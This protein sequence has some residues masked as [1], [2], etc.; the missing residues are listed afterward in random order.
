MASATLPCVPNGAMGRSFESAG[1]RQ[2]LDRSRPSRALCIIGQSQVHADIADL[3]EQHLQQ[4]QT[5]KVTLVRLKTAEALAKRKE[6]NQTNTTN[7]G[8]LKT[9][10]CIKHRED[11]FGCTLSVIDIDAFTSKESFEAAAES[12]LDA[13]RVHLR[14]RN[15]RQAVVVVTKADRFPFYDKTETAQNA[16]KKKCDLDSAKSVSV[17]HLIR[18]TFDCVVRLIHDAQ[19]VALLYYRDEC[20][21]LKKVRDGSS[22]GGQLTVLTSAPNPKLLLARHQFKIGYFYEVRG[23]VGE[24]V[25]HYREAYDLLKKCALATTGQQAPQAS[26]AP[27]TFSGQPE[28][29]SGHTPQRI[30]HHSASSAPSAPMHN[31]GS[32]ASPAAPAVCAGLP[33][34]CE[35]KSALEVVVFRLAFLTMLH[36]ASGV[37]IVDGGAP[38]D[39]IDAEGRLSEK[40]RRFVLFFRDHMEWFR[41]VGC[42]GGQGYASA[43]SDVK[44]SGGSSGGGGRMMNRLLHGRA[45]EGLGMGMVSEMNA[46]ASAPRFVA[47][48]HYTMVARQHETFHWVLTAL[49]AGRVVNKYDKH[50]VDAYANPGFHLQ[51]ASGAALSLA[52]LYEGLSARG[53]AGDKPAVKVPL[54]LGQSCCD[55]DDASERYLSELARTA[56][57]RAEPLEEVLR[58]SGNAKQCFE[59]SASRGNMAL[60]VVGAKSLLALGKP[61]EALQAIEVAAK[62]FSAK[63]WPGVAETVFRIQMHCWMLLGSPQPFCRAFFDYVS[64]CTA[65][66]AQPLPADFFVLGLTSQKS[67]FDAVVACFKKQALPADPPSTPQLVPQ[68]FVPSELRD[69]LT[70]K[71]QTIHENLLEDSD[72]TS[73]EDAVLDLRVEATHPFVSQL[74]HFS[75]PLA[76]VTDVNCALKVRVSTQLA[77]KVPV[78]KVLVQLAHGGQVFEDM[79]EGTHITK[80][81]DIVLTFAINPKDV[82]VIRVASITTY[83][84]ILRVTRKV[85]ECPEL[86]N[87]LH[88]LSERAGAVGPG[89]LPS[90]WAE[91]CAIPLVQGNVGTTD[92][93]CI[94]QSNALSGGYGTAASSPYGA[95]RSPFLDRPVLRVLK[96]QPT[97]TLTLT[98]QYALLFPLPAPFT[99][100]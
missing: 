67:F 61:D 56:E 95:T 99:Y 11:V 48:A 22:K 71:P 93:G 7:K 9:A 98:H 41:T 15:T 23:K 30:V 63:P 96:P 92:S 21:R 65:G 4:T 14:G 46:F 89:G 83:I 64:Q 25:Q 86:V 5:L 36:N 79:P 19:E 2:Y 17:V 84:G 27:A 43:A 18:D 60:S 51:S 97:L 32:S 20:K 80:G 24:A 87:K 39:L 78:D 1:L 34:L 55:S 91:H 6:K 50:N 53:S 90:L 100:S 42:G 33:A 26:P 8:V 40:V 44:S 45:D 47:L 82:G 94:A 3:I 52:V 12:Q 85:G 16:L 68:V 66:P 37:C 10:W 62:Y 59:G 35:I 31:F 77:H 75:S 72:E 70:T 73:R 54:F 58:L 74:A 57:G 88:Q 28:S 81:H 76:Y 13:L 29:L 69:F 38:D 49:T